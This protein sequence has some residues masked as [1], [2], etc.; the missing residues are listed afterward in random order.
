M[1]RQLLMTI[2]LCA[3]LS[4]CAVGRPSATARWAKSV[5]GLRKSADRHVSVGDLKLAEADLR[6]IFSLAPPQDAPRAYQLL[7]DAHFALGS[8]LL[9]KGQVDEALAEADKGLSLGDDQ[10]IFG[11][12]LHAL[13]GLCKEQKGQPIDALED[14]GRALDVHKA[15][16]DKALATH[17]QE[18]G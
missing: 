8:V 11:A 1:T 15:L 3:A 14:Y 7:Q 5:D 18:K 10:S 2:G 13:K 16:F 12:N 6:R 4:S 17:E 9:L